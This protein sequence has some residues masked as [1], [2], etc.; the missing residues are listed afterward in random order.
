MAWRVGE[1]KGGGSQCVTGRRQGEPGKFQSRVGAGGA[2]VIT[3]EDGLISLQVASSRCSSKRASS[4]IC[5]YLD[6]VY[7]I[8]K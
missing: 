7:V 6:S 8:M 2:G 3:R 1:V 4:D 5:F